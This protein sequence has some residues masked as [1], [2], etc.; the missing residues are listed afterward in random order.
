MADP[1]EFQDHALPGAMKA[2]TATRITRRV[3]MLSVA[4]ASVLIALKLWAWLASGSVAMLSSLADSGLD[5]VASLFTLLAVTYAAQPPDAEHRYGHGK[6]EAF[7]ALLQALLVGVSATLVAVEAIERFR[8]PKPIAESTL[9][10]GV[11]GASIVLTL[12]L[13]WAQTLAVRQTGSVATHGDRAHYAADLAANVAVIGGIGAAAMF[14]VAWAD[15]LVGLGVALWLAW[16]ALDVARGGLDQLLDRELPDDARARIRDLAMQSGGLLDVHMLRTRASGPYVHIQFHA[17]LPPG[18]S[19]IE[20]HQRMVAAEQSILKEFPA[21]D[22]LIHPDPRGEAAPHG[23]DVF[24][25]PGHE[26]AAA[27]GQ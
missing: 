13:I 20:A 11:M 24:A 4:T 9:A 21:A 15:P 25:E 2:S 8:T 19:L 5:G 18:L 6:A 17:D 26:E 27:D 7:A 16:S 12:A 3:A 14:G 23:S 10:L 22:I 1:A